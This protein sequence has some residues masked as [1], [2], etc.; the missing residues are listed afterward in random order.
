MAILDSLNG[1]DFVAF[2]K[3]HRCSI[4]GCNNNLIDAD[5]LNTVGMGRNRKNPSLTEHF[6]CVPL[7]RAHHT[8]RHTMPLEDFE[9]KHGVNLWKDNHRLLILWLSET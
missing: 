3:L 1:L 7:C 9:S 5:H 2:V 8:E 4:L 6:S